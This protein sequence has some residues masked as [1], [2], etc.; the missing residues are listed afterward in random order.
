VVHFSITHVLF[1]EDRWE[2]QERIASLLRS[3]DG[4]PLDLVCAASLN[5]AVELATRRRIDVLVLGPSL[6][7]QASLHLRNVPIVVLNDGDESD[8]PR[9]IAAGA[10]DYLAK[11]T[12]TP[13]LLARALR[14]AIERHAMLRE[15]ERLSLT[16]ELTGL[17]NRRG[18]FMLGEQQLECARR[19]RLPLLL[20]YADV[21]GLK[22]VN[23]THGHAAGDRLLADAARIMTA[24]FR[25]ADIVARIGGDEFA[26]LAQLA[27]ADA[28]RPELRLLEKID[29]RNDAHPTLPPIGLSIGIELLQPEATRALG[30]FLSAADARM[31][32]R[33][34]DIRRSTRG[35]RATSEPMSTTLTGSQCE[36]GFVAQT[37]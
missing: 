7:T 32:E 22:R 25:S 12:L 14:Y 4:L 37:D 36:S 35:L 11:S 30:D 1:I 21:D 19:A 6:I 3:A 5:E 9:A 24:T 31:Y 29:T 13:P 17:Y 18:F 34:R 26:I 28:H 2:E 20:M 27:K 23:D 10:Q 8:A 33:R 15:L 16:D